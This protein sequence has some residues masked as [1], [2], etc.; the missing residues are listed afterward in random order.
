[1]V[2]TKYPYDWGTTTVKVILQ[3]KVQLGHIVSH[4]T[5]KPSFKRKVTV[6]VPEEEWIEVPHTHE[7]LMKKP[8]V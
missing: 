2:N 5:T 7:P 3:N 8:L 6:T 4:K 1:M